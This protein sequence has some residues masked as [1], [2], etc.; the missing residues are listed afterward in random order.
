MKILIIGGDGQD[1]RILSEIS[2]KHEVT[3]TTRRKKNDENSVFIDLTRPAQIYEFLINNR[4]D[5]IYYCAAVNG[6]DGYDYESHIEASYSVNV[7]GVNQCLQALA[8]KKAKDRFIYFNSGKV[9]DKS[10]CRIDENSVKVN[11]GLYELQ[12][13]TTYE[14]IKIYR[15]KYGLELTNVWLFNHESDYR[16]NNYFSAKITDFIVGY[17]VSKQSIGKLKLKNLSFQK[18]WGDAYEYMKIIQ[19]IGMRHSEDYILATGE[20]ENANSLVRN[21][22]NDHDIPE[23]LLEIEEFNQVEFAPTIDISKMKMLSGRSPERNALQ[24]FRSIIDKKLSK[25]KKI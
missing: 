5:H 1:G 25:L 19:E 4:F 15:K 16:S 13:N 2:S 7:V 8:E 22:F 20:N 9:F 23:K 12:K 3:K 24:T 18:D 14:L 17:K 21:L 6:S 11:H 10:I